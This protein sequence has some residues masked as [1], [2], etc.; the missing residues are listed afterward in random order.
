MQGVSYRASAQDEARRLGLLGWVRNLPNGDVEA[1]AQGPDEA[2]ARFIA[3]CRIGPDEARVK[4]VV[5]SER[6]E[7]NAL[8]PFEVRR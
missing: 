4:D 3:W 2:I 1:T 6:P 7:S 8:R 5:V